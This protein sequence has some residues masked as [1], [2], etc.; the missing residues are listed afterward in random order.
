M[1]PLW[2]VEIETQPQRWISHDTYHCLYH[3]LPPEKHVGYELRDRGHSHE[4]IAHEY[5]M[6]RSSFIVVLYL[7]ICNMWLLFPL[8]VIQLLIDCC[9]LL[10]VWFCCCC[11][12]VLVLHCCKH[13]RLSCALNHLLT[14]LLTYDSETYRSTASNLRSHKSPLMT[15]QNTSVIGLGTQGSEPG[16][17]TE[18][19]I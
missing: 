8:C 17:F 1:S 11:C 13:M 18:I 5:K 6:T 19:I 12:C 3:L 16:K 4:L 9:F 15:V 7:I 2:S 14:Y 10:T